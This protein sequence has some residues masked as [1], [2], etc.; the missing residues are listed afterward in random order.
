MRWHIAR[1]YDPKEWHRWFA[2]HPV[3]VGDE[4]VWLEPVERRIEF[5]C[6]DDFPEYRNLQRKGS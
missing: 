2:W 6:Y 5:G 3:C 4:L 1:S